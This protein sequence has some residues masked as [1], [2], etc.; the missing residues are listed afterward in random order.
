MKKLLFRTLDD[1]DT[2]GFKVFL[3]GGLGLGFAA[4][5]GGTGSFGVV[6]GA[7]I[8]FLVA[9]VSYCLGVIINMIV[10]A[11]WQARKRR[12]KQ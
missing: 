11:F 7:L 1:E 5:I 12:S 2:A 9:A 8:W 4:F 3:F 10:E 6:Q